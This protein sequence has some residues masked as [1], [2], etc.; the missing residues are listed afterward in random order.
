MMFTSR[1][2][3][4]ESILNLQTSLRLRPS[5][6]LECS[7]SVVFMTH[8]Y[9]YFVSV[10]Q[11][12]GTVHCIIPRFIY[13]P[14]YFSLIQPSSGINY[15]MKITQEENVSIDLTLRSVRVTIVVVKKKSN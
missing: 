9:M 3:S 5:N 13:D 12:A 1:I 6:S 14:K 15:V 11:W 2:C 7:R 8:N 4:Y 10:L